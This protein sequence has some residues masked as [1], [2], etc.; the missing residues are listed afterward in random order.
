MSLSCSTLETILAA[1]GEAQKHQFL[2]VRLTDL[3]PL[4]CLRFFP[5]HILLGA[6]TGLD[7]MDHEY[8]YELH[9]YEYVT[10]PLC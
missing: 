5:E 7:T 1:K 4:Y 6:G 9:T 3:K 2:G 10:S 8:E